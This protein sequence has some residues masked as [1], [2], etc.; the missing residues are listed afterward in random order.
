MPLESE[1]PAWLSVT[2]IAP[3]SP[4][5]DAVCAPLCATVTCR[6][7]VRCGRSG[8]RSL[9]TSWPAME[10]STWPVKGAAS[11]AGVKVLFPAVEAVKR[12]KVTVTENE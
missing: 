1:S 7:L 6:G 2:M 11:M 4:E 8:M 9:E 3:D 5:E 10:N 12:E